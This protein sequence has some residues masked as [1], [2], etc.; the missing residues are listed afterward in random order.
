[1]K[2][3]S[4]LLQSLKSTV[5]KPVIRAGMVKEEEVQG[6]GLGTKY[7]VITAQDNAI[8]LVEWS[9]QEAKRLN[10]YY[11]KYGAVLFRGFSLKNEQ[12]FQSF[13]QS[14]ATEMLDYTEPSTP[15]TKVEG[16][17]YTSTE[18][19]KDRS[20]PQHNEHSYTSTFP[21]KIWFYCA[22]AATTGGE[23]PIADAGLVYDL[24]PAGLRSRYAE[25]GILYKRNYHK[26][27]DL[28]W[29]HVFGTDDRTTVEEHCK[30][31]GIAYKWKEDD[32]LQTQYV[33]QTVTR[34]PVTNQLLWFNQ[35]HLF[36]LRS[37]P[38]TV[39][40]Y[41]K[42]T[43][44]ED[45][46]PRNSY[47]GDETPI[48]ETDYNAI[49][50]AYEKAKVTFGWEAGDVLWLDN[51]RFTHGRNPFD[52]DR[53][54]LVAMADPYT[55]AAHKNGHSNGT[56]ASSVRQQTSAY[57]IKKERPQTE[58]WLKYRLAGLYRILA[59]EKLDEGI[60]GH[61][62][63]K[64]PGENELFWVNPF[65]YF[66]EEVTPDNLIMVDLQGK[67]VSGNHPINVA[68]FFIHA[69]LHAARPEINCIVHTHS[70]LGTVFTSLGLSI[71]AIDQT[72]CMFYEKHALYNGY[73]GPVL[74]EEE[75][76]N[77]VNAAKDKHTLLLRNHGTITMGA[78]L[79]TAA[80]L[81]ISAE[82]AYHVNLNARAIGNPIPVAPEIART[83]Q[84]WIANPIGM[85]I[86]FDAYLRKAERYY[87]DLKNFRPQN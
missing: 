13:C 27:L 71:E 57:F 43:F 10:D 37:L 77:L 56:D 42:E 1:M 69:A 16:K 72:S 75:G 65:G 73:N 70:P 3:K 52:G 28:P 25:K 38:E 46:V 35:A 24:L 86:E 18:Y 53:K 61:I 83:T 20:I 21:Q 8:D 36:N 64:V 51:M 34:H 29:Q 59:M 15:R 48:T 54:V 9:S 80:M 50:D 17:V 84:Q 68:G 5:P 85:Q 31:S 82:H 6:N 22:T 74:D 32:A 47:L 33:A 40:E 41:F 14:F 76:D 78:E 7:M 66:F 4:Q 63:L 23:T 55:V 39:Q 45:N 30:K 12:A 44:G 26:N 87:P 2:S 19:P 58:A 67:I 11:Q 79:E 49:T 60:S 81:M 62:S